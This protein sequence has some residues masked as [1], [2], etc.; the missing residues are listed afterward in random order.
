M[1]KLHSRKH[2]LKLFNFAWWQK[3]CF[4][5]RIFQKNWYPYYKKI[6]ETY[7]HV[8][9]CLALN[10]QHTILWK[11]TI[12]GMICFCSIIAKVS[13]T[14]PLPYS[15]WMYLHNMYAQRKAQLLS[16]NLEV[17]VLIGCTLHWF[18]INFLSDA[19]GNYCIPQIPL[20]S[21]QPTSLLISCLKSRSNPF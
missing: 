12:L 3:F 7:S 10:P 6:V 13:D 15:V 18:L 21:M 2:S 11:Y 16:L 5:T 8:L 9:N 17:A 19:E 20:F 14:Q 4:V 1:G